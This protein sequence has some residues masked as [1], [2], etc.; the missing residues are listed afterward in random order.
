MAEA[1]PR[2]GA[3]A[4]SGSKPRGASRLAAG[5]GGGASSSPAARATRQGIG[6]ALAMRGGFWGR[7]HGGGQTLSA[8]RSPSP[9]A[10]GRGQADAPAGASAAASEFL[11]VP[12][13]VEGSDAVCAAPVAP[14][15][16]FSFPQADALARE[17]VPL[18][19]LSVWD[20]LPWYVA[21]KKVESAVVALPAAGSPSPE[22]GDDAARKAAFFAH[23]YR[24]GER[25]LQRLSH[26]YETLLSGDSEQR[27]FLHLARQSTLAASPAAHPKTNSK[28]RKRAKRGGEEDE[29]DE[30][31]GDGGGFEGAEGFNGNAP[32]KGTKGDTLSALSLLIQQQPLCACTWLYKLLYMISARRRASEGG[33][34][35][36]GGHCQQ[37]IEAAFTLFDGPL[38]LPAY[39]KLRTCAQQPDWLRDRVYGLL[40][41][42]GAA[43]APKENGGEALL[44]L[45]ML[46]RIEAEFKT[47][48]ATFVQ[49]LSDSTADSVVHFARRSLRLA[50]SLLMRK[51]E[52]EQ[53]LLALIVNALGSRENQVASS[54]SHLLAQLLVRHAPMKPVVAVYVGSFLLSQLREALHRARSAASQTWEELR[55]TSS[56]AFRKKEKRRRRRLAERRGAGVADLEAVEEEAP[57][58]SGRDIEKNKRVETLYRLIRRLGGARNEKADVAQGDGEEKVKKARGFF[59]QHH[60]VRPLPPAEVKALQQQVLTLLMP[61]KLVDSLQSVYRAVLF[62]SEL[63]F[64]K[65]TDAE[66]AAQ[67]TRIYLQVFT[68]L[69]RFPSSLRTRLA[70]PAGA[71][72]SMRDGDGPPPPF[73]P[74][75]YQLASLNRLVRALLNGL[76][77]ALPY[78]P[79]DF[80]SSAFS[81]VLGAPV[82]ARPDAKETH[83]GEDEMLETLYTLVHTLPSMASRIVVLRLLHRIVVG[84]NLPLDRLSR[85]VYEHLNDPEAF[86]ASNRAAL[87]SLVSSLTLSASSAEALP[88]APLSASEELLSVQRRA[89]FCKRLLQAGLAHAD[90]PGV[91]AAAALVSALLVVHE[92]DAAMQSRKF[93][94]NDECRVEQML[95]E[96]ERDLQAES[97]DKASGVEG[98]RQK[99]KSKNSKNRGAESETEGE[100]ASRPACVYDP[101]KRDP[102]YSRASETRLWELAAASAFYHPAVSSVAGSTIA[103]V[104]GGE[105]SKSKKNAFLARKDKRRYHVE[106]LMGYDEDSVGQLVTSL[107]HSRVLDLLAYKPRAEVG[108]EAEKGREKKRKDEEGNK[109]KGPFYLGRAAAFPL[110][111]A[112]H[113]RARGDRVPPQEKFMASYF[114]DPFVAETEALRRRKR[115]LGERDEE[116]SGDEDKMHESDEEEKDEQML[117]DEEVD[118]FLSEQLAAQFGAG[119]EDDEDEDEDDMGDDDGEEEQDREGEE[120]EDDDADDGEGGGEDMSEAGEKE[121]DEDEGDMGTLSSGDEEIDDGIFGGDGDDDEDEEPAPPAKGKQRKSP[122][123][124]LRDA[125]LKRLREHVKRHSSVG[126]GGSSSFVS[127][128][129]LEDLLRG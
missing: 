57:S 18:D 74:P 89:A 30:A 34:R 47:I 31:A 106:Q 39:R 51:K 76:H 50:W 7:G 105:K 4:A 24:L 61:S 54:A 6:D 120:E 19:W 11:A 67:V 9:R 80:A 87:L 38:L 119:E 88:A 14:A 52:E 17:C 85:V 22:S 13:A 70:R 81:S 25:L 71:S 35:T 121:D 1:P 113:W 103:G 59:P 122:G 55:L 21:L 93:K 28:D 36:W 92:K 123:K 104:C 91:A 79:A 110:D 116:G 82:A 127:A 78:V 46:W 124:E 111:S 69:H 84:S 53:R 72:Q 2:R 101:T 66:V 73:L 20:R 86:A 43:A 109:T 37:A 48:Y 15:S 41:R 98:E 108:A 3:A 94:R 16:S 33:R 97:E 117:S 12:E 27:W 62:F 44:Q 77:R 118:A 56:V 23:F 65:D 114:Q 63:Q 83:D 10:R 112:R 95:S 115:K 29:E 100:E 126:E 49:L 26:D 75:L 64:H 96:K 32:K 129:G 125:R 45:A 68:Q 58:K 90:P 42:A 40:G 60:R 102:R 8:D 107:T 5:R 128:E 99:K